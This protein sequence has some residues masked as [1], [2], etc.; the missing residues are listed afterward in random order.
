MTTQRPSSYE[1]WLRLSDEQ[2]REV[3][4]GWNVY[5]REGFG[6]PICAVGRLAIQS[7]VKVYEV[8]VGTWHGGEYILHAYV[9][10]ED[11]PKMPQPLEQTFEGFR[12]FWMPVSK[13][14]GLC[15]KKSEE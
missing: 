11:H 10:D 14:S 3:H 8:K 2:K 1:E 5:D 9:A 4:R 13:H 6:F 7:P 15:Y 12:V